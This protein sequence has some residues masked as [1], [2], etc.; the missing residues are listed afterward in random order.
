MMLE[1]LAE[2]ARVQYLL[3]HSRRDQKLVDDIALTRLRYER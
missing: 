3:E 2:K 1:K